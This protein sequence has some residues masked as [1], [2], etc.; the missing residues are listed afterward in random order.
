M[1]LRRIFLILLYIT[2]T[3]K[4]VCA[5]VAP[6][7]ALDLPT[8]VKESNIIVL[9][10]VTSVREEGRMII[11]IWEK[12]IAARK[13]I[14]ILDVDKVLKG[15]LN[16][17]NIQIG[18]F[19]PELPL[20]YKDVTVNQIGIFFLRED[21]IVQNP[22]Y[23]FIVAARGAPSEEGDVLD[24]IIAQLA[25]VLITPEVSLDE[26]K[27]AVEVLSSVK[28]TTAT[29]YLRRAV[30]SYDISLRFQAM[31]ALLRRND[32]SYLKTVEEILMQPPQNVD[33]ALINALAFALQDGVRDPLAIPSLTRL[34]QAPDVQT[35]RGAAAALRHTDVISAIRPL[36]LA[37]DD[38]DKE[39]RFQAV[40]GLAVLTG[41]TDYAPS[42]S[43]YEQ[44][45]K[46]Y[47]DY[48]QNWVRKR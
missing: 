6:I 19:I 2:A 11:N 44:N 15:N 36:S 46:R 25:H 47:L 12:N 23:P 35:R 17:S 3:L 20:G 40:L 42:I 10:Q 31:A 9:G 29:E 34:L 32:V 30:Q 7:P 33:M 1:L 13:M 28:T 38:S 8:L 43:L 27:Q 24:R 4:I 37:L 48:W 39:V 14:A 45:E 26:R 16:V 5:T 41:N 18:F 21:Y 22:Y